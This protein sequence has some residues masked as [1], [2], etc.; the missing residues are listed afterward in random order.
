M[1]MTETVG[2]TE[3]ENLFEWDKSFED[4][5]EYGECNNAVTHQIVCPCWEGKERICTMHS[6]EFPLFPDM[7]LIFDRTCAHS[8]MVRDCVIIPVE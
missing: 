2:E 3:I 4:T 5:C 8:P 1:S 6:Q 7:S